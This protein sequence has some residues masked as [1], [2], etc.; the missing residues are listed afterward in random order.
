VLVGAAGIMDR[1]KLIAMF[2]GLII[3]AAL[4]YLLFDSLNDP[5]QVCSPN[6][7]GCGKPPVTH[8]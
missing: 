2:S 8:L 3:L 5:N 1:L 6:G 4:A 7:T